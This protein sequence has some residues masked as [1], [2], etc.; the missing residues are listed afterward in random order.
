M[1]NR[2]LLILSVGAAG[3]IGSLAWLKG[4]RTPPRAAALDP[5]APTKTVEAAPQEWQGT[6][7]SPRTVH[8]QARTTPASPASLISRLLQGEEIPKPA[9][10]E[11]ES[12][13]DANHRSTGSL[14][15]AFRATG[16][17]NFL[18]EA[19]EKAPNDPRVA[20]AAYWFGT[21]AKYDDPASPERRQWLEKLKESDPNNALGNL[22]SARD[23]LNVGQPDKAL[24]ELNAASS[25]SVYRDYSLE[26]IQDAEEAY[27]GAGLSEAEAKVVACAELP[28]PH[29]AQLKKL[30]QGVMDLAG[31]YRQAGDEASAQAVLQM[32]LN[33]GQRLR[34][35][36]DQFLIQELVGIAAER[37]A[38]AGFDPSAPYGS[39]GQTVK[40]RLDQIVQE[41]EQIKV[42]GKQ[43]EG[44]LPT[45]SEQDLVTYFERVKT[46]GE[47]A[48]TRW[49]VEKY[50]R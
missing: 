10:A 8:P 24:A 18:K 37:I 20:F 17:T 6:I 5:A 33:V 41:R 34:S 9:A 4:L 42:L 23:Y 1:M 36:G 3:L 40:D 30:V 31:T 26:F 46:L 47:T 27:R 29:L 21:Q 43:V 28:L 2:S 14:L 49:A 35:G 7:R 44:L 12:F 11:L 25:Q 50:A 48:A 39:E 38:L 16:D 22:L 15:G 32:G 19:M 45:M 13:L